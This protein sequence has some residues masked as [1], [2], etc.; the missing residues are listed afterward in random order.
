MAPIILPFGHVRATSAQPH[1]AVGQSEGTLLQFSLHQASVPP[2]PGSAT[3][4]VPLGHV[5]LP[6]TTFSSTTFAYFLSPPSGSWVSALPHLDE[7]QFEGTCLQFVLHHSSVPPVP[8]SAA[9]SPLG[10]VV[11]DVTP[12]GDVVSEANGQVPSV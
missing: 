12:Q 1:L 10:R 8:G 2:I 3:Y 7:G 11:L 9:Y 4:T 5:V 6:C